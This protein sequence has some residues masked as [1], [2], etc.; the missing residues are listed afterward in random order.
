L[1]IPAAIACYN[2]FYDKKLWLVIL[3][4]VIVIL[5]LLLSVNLRT[6]EDISDLIPTQPRYLT[7][8]FT[9]I[10]NAPFMRI[11]AVTVGGEDNHAA[12]A[13]MLCESIKCSILPEVM[14][15]I[16]SVFSPN[17]L[18]N[19]IRYTPNLLTVNQ[20]TQLH[21][22]LSKAYIQNAIA[23][24]KRDLLGPTGIFTQKLT[25]IDP[26]RLR[27]LFIKDILSADS[28]G[29]F[30]LNDGFFTDKS[31]KYSLVLA[32]PA[33]SMTDS[34]GSVKI[35]TKIRDAISNLSEKNEIYIQGSYVH[36]EE[37][38]NI[39]KSDLRRIIPISFVVLTFLLILFFRNAYSMI[40]LCIPVISLMSSIAILSML[41]NTISGIVLS[42]A[43][44]IL[45]ITVDYAIHTY[46]VLSPS[47]D[48]LNSLSRLSA[49][50]LA[51]ALTTLSAFVSL[52]FSDIP[53]IKQMSLFGVSGILAALIVSIYV[54]PHFVTLRPQKPLPPEHPAKP[55]KFSFLLLIALASISLFVIIRGISS[56]RIDGDIRNLAWKSGATLSDEEKT[57]NIWGFNNQSIIIVS[58]GE[59]GEQG[60]EK[61]L[62]INDNVWD[63]LKKEHI[64][65]SSI[66]PLLPSEQRQRV[67]REIWRDFWQQ[68]GQNILEEVK[69]I[70]SQA[71]FSTFA[72]AQFVSLIN[73]EPPI[74][75][76]AT[77]R[78]MGVGFFLDMF[79][80]TTHDANL[81]YTIVQTDEKISPEVHSRL[82]LA[83]ARLVSGEL[84][85]QKIAGA[86]SDEIK[87]FCS[88]TFF[89]TLCVVVLLFRTPR[90]CLPALLPMFTSLAA[91]L[92]L[93]LLF[94]IPVNI[95]HAM[96][97]P[98]VI[99]LSVDYGIFMQSSLETHTTHST[100][101]GIILSGLT[102]LVGFG[103][104][105]LAHHP[106]LHSIG[107]TVTTGITT[108]MATALWLLPRLLRG[109]NT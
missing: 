60:L 42:F 68:D 59:D 26:L 80:A 41:Y 27:D 39:I 38:A 71:G 13:V 64:G 57:R 35:M 36:T 94:D 97:L 53:A 76:P 99:A 44:V 3:H 48:I 43:S 40:A 81:V 70:Q 25:A 49:A 58:E 84:F 18:E 23:R 88:V 51:C 24:N 98:L 21:D 11:I 62:R 91:T 101:K 54:L 5:S 7:R 19:L 79:V 63:I 30:N 87:R 9:F 56:L 29:K 47:I 52:Y 61:A 104:L 85:R 37:N 50:L 105:L 66:A 55:L 28:L 65:A 72:S 74:I 90:R 77:L 16:D 95:F 17:F 102:T 22:T 109:Q 100:E 10:K 34:D 103:C 93:F 15:G 46:F 67:R 8:D 106:A 69:K 32:K 83:G 82:F 108:A 14:T 89:M 1:R 6:S 33:V 20:L 45:G 2:F 73:S 96:S 86:F 12:H 92:L 78:E 107:I 31:G 75:V 4:A